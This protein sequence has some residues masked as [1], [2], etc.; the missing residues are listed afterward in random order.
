[1]NT[2]VCEV[3]KVGLIWLESLQVLCDVFLE[4]LDVSSASEA[5]EA[6]LCN[7]VGNCLFEGI[8]YVPPSYTNTSPLCL[9]VRSEKIIT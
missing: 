6:C 1:M 5:E 2:L 8:D 4:G 7:L 9:C 3:L